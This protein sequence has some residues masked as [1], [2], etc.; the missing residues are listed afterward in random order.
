MPTEP[1]KNYVPRVTGFF[2]LRETVDDKTIESAVRT[3]GVDRD[4]SD[5]D[6]LRLSCDTQL[7]DSTFGT[8]NQTPISSDEFRGFPKPTVYMDYATIKIGG[9]PY[10]VDALICSPTMNS[11]VGFDVT[12]SVQVTE[13][14]NFDEDGITIKTAT[15]TF[16]EGSTTPD[17]FTN[18]VDLGS[19][20][21]Q[22][23]SQIP[24][25][26]PT[27]DIVVDVGWL[28]GDVP[29]YSGDGISYSDVLENDPIPPTYN[30]DIENFTGLGC[31]SLGLGTFQNVYS[32]FSASSVS[33][34]STLY[35]DVGLSNPIPD[36][37]Y[38]FWQIGVQSFTYGY[39]TNG[40]VG[41]FTGCEGDIIE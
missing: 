13:I 8:Q 40:V 18:V 9:G 14:P 20:I 3:T 41:S 33:E 7:I 1:T 30:Y 2:I 39:V 15:F 34:G 11:K 19:G 23:N 35:T 16:N 4:Y 28:G 17:S 32:N 38:I 10:G 22:L 21:Y 5:F 12:I 29:V 25:F 31:A 26:A 27:V 6:D 24:T 37:W 36:G